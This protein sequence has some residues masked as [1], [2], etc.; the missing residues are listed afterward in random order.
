MRKSTSHACCCN[1]PCEKQKQ[2]RPK[3]VLVAT[4]LVLVATK[5]RFWSGLSRTHLSALVTTLQHWAVLPVVH[6]QLFVGEGRVVLA[7]ELTS[8]CHVICLLFLLLF[9][10]GFLKN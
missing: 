2:K 5:E 3:L 4:K 9:A 8:A 6:V 10:L 1:T 7:T